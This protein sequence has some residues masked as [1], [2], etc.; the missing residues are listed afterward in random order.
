MEQGN[1]VKGHGRRTCR[2]GFSMIWK[3]G[4]AGANFKRLAE[5]GADAATQL[6]SGTRDGQASAGSRERENDARD[7]KSDD[8]D[9]VYTGGISVWSVG[10]SGRAA[11]RQGGRGPAEAAEDWW[12]FEF[13][14]EGLCVFADGSR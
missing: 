3:A 1:L 7:E 11:H 6:A 10:G 14:G 4:E 2:L 8:T 5:G 13:V 12:K 9:A